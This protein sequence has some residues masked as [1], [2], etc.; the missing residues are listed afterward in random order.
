MVLIFTVR[1]LLALV[2]A[3]MTCCTPALGTASDW[4]DPTVT[5]PPPPPPPPV[6]LP[7]L[8][9]DELQDAS[10]GGV[11]SSALAPRAPRRSVR[12]DIP[13]A[14]VGTMRARYSA[15][16]EGRA[17]T[18]GSFDGERVMGRRRLVHKA[19][20]TTRNPQCRH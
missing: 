18:W 9:L 19:T 5:V 12:R 2:K 3:S 16:V 1:P 13:L 11:A 15:S 8:P 17:M 14:E 10:S 20:G 7:L 4:F 6:A